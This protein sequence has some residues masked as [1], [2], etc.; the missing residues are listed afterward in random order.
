MA[1]YQKVYLRLPLNTASL[2][3]EVQ[4]RLST[5]LGEGLPTGLGGKVEHVEP[6]HK[7]GIHLNSKVTL[8]QS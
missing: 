3:A 7:E 8:F 6:R 2:A 5:S 1:D 4:S